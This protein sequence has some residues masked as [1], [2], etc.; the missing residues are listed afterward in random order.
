MRAGTLVPA[1]PLVR[2]QQPA[3]RCALNEGRNFSSGNTL[4]VCSMKAHA[5]SLN[6]GRNFSSGNTH[7]RCQRGRGQHP[8]NEGRNF[9]SG[10]TATAPQSADYSIKT[11]NEGRNFS[12]GNTGRQTRWL[13]PPVERSMRAGTLVPATLGGGWVGG[14]RF[15]SLNEGRNFS[16][17]NTLTPA[18]RTGRWLPRSM[19]AGTLVPATLPRAHSDG[20]DRHAQ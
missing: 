10:N 3:V 1:T 13:A 14:T 12:S 17:G 18:S 2:P 4:T 5:S 9:S 15:W 7:I 8:L 6:E 11:L 20:S 16:S 19:R